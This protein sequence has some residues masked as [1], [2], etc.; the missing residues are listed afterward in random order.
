MVLCQWG[1]SVWLHTNGNIKKVAACKVKPYELVDR[2][3]IKER[4]KQVSKPVMLEDSL[5]SVEN[6]MDKKDNLTS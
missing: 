3:A 6:L 2:E 5:E 4:G 1:Q